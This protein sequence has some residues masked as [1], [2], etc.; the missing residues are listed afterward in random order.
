VQRLDEQRRV[1]AFLARPRRGA[2]DHVGRDV[3]AVD[4]VSSP[5]PGQEHPAGAAAGVEGWLTLGDEPPEELDLVPADGELRPP[6]GDE[7]VVP[8]LRL[9]AHVPIIAR[10]GA[11]EST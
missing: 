11:W 7:A 2:L 5:K 10:L 6:V 9:P 4:V 8:R 1:E 3:C